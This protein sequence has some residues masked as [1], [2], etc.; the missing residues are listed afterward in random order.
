MFNNVDRTA[1]YLNYLWAYA[2]DRPEVHLRMTKCNI[3]PDLAKLNME[4]IA[5]G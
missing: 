3:F 4:A 5:S 2:G 1:R